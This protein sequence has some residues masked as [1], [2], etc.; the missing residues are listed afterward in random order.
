M[1]AVNSVFVAGGRFDSF[2][3]SISIAV[4]IAFYLIFSRHFAALKTTNALLGL[5]ANWAS[6]QSLSSP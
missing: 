5:I 3:W 1:R 4:G 2:P 6:S